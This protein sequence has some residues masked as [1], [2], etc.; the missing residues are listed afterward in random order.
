MQVNDFLYRADSVHSVAQSYPNTVL[1]LIL[2]ISVVAA[3]AGLA[4]TAGTSALDSSAIGS[5]GGLCEYAETSEQSTLVDQTI[6]VGANSTG[7]I[8]FTVPNEEVAVRV[9]TDALTIA[10]PEIVIEGPNGG[11][12]L[13]SSVDT[14]SE[15]DIGVLG[16]GTYT[17]KVINEG[18]GSADI[19]TTV[20]AGLCS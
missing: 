8:R 3:G 19:D 17:L 5:S 15:R 4:I 14:V 18:M 13:Q 9:N 10:T 20:R 7:E 11:T 12:F 16:S 2:G 1:L 6:Q